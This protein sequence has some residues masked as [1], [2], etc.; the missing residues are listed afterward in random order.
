MEL[1]K[2]RCLPCEGFVKALSKK[3]YFP[4]LKKVPK[5][6]LKAEKISRKFIFK[7]FK[8]AMV[9]V[10]N[11]AT[12]AES[13]GHHP[14]ISIHWNEVSLELWTH[15]LNGLSQNDFVLAAKIDRIKK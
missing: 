13:E 1:A 2:K 10:N 11:V 5:W 6:S 9:F 15:A 7:D 12:I 8:E 3:E 14:D 4:L